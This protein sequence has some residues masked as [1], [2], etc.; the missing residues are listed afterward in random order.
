MKNWQKI[1]TFL[2]VLIKKKK[3]EMWLDYTNVHKKVIKV[4]LEIP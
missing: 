1:A 3:G 4:Q 2:P